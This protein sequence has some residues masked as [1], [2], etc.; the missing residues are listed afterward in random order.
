M[1]SLEILNIVLS[2]VGLLLGIFIPI[3]TWRASNKATKKLV[4]DT[5]G[6]SSV[7]NA[8]KASM[9]KKYTEKQQEVVAK[10]ISRSAGVPLATLLN[11]PQERFNIFKGL[12]DPNEYPWDSKLSK[13]VK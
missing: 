11:N 7:T 8:V 13:F 6:Y 9:N 5:F 2:V 12:S 10:I 1:N 4:T 3:V